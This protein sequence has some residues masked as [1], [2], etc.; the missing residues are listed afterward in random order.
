[1]NKDRIVSYD[2]D[3]DDRLRVL[4]RTDEKGTTTLLRTDG[5]D[6]LTPIYETSVTEQAYIVNWNEDN[7]K[8]YLISNKG[9]LD[10][11]TL[12]LFDPQTTAV[13][14]IESDPK[15]KVDIDGVNFDINTRKII[16]TTYT[17]DKTEYYWKNKTWEA[18][19]KFLKSKFPGR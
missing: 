8:C 7:S 17:T 19:Y 4:Y 13:T 16:S 14:K 6:K 18:N 9:E 3:W 5:N 2:F 12:F 11:S 1:E 10:L 15:G